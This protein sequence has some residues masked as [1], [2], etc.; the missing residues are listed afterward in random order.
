M[1]LDPRLPLDFGRA[2]KNRIVLRANYDLQNGFKE[3]GSTNAYT[4]MVKGCM[5]Q[6]WMQRRPLIELT[7]YCK[8]LLDDKNEKHPTYG[9]KKKKS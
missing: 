6:C 2:G 7:E 4:F 9:T 1:K 3:H 8:L 5:V